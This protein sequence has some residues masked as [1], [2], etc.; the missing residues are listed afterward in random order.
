M[1]KEQAKYARQSYENYG[2]KENINYKKG[3]TKSKM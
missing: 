2:N 1:R 3:G